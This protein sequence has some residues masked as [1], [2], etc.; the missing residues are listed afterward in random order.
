MKTK[1]IIESKIAKIPH[2][3]VFG[4]Q[5]ILNDTKKREAAIKALNR[6]VKSGQ[7][8]KIAKGKFYKPK[9][10]IFGVLKPDMA[11]LIKDLLEI[12]GKP[13]GYVT[14][15]GV[16]NQLG[17]TTQVSAVIHIG[18]NTTRP[19]TQREQY[20]IFFIQ[21]KNII[22]KRN[23]PLL[24]ILDAIRDIKK[25]PD[26]SLLNIVKRLQAIIGDISSKDKHEMVKLALNYPPSTRAVLGFILD[27]SADAQIAEPLRE[28]LNPLTTYNIG[29]SRHW[30]DARK[31]NIR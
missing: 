26:T 6:M 9:E 22:T 30:L 19:R 12:N 31:W 21:Q 14:G 23:I 13:V 27:T 10:T 3:F 1:D 16:F 8:E 11:Q 7:L 5:D 25:I 18:R 2:G 24:R 4:Y 17:L 29:I 20:R 28:S 15:L